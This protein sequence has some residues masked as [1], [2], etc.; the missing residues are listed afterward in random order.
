M[1]IGLAVVPGSPIEQAV[2]LLR[3]NGY[4]VIKL[5]TGSGRRSVSGCDAACT[6]SKHTA[7]CYA[8]RYRQLRKQTGGRRS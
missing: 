7:A 4:R 2:A 1:G 8:R 5:G 3:A 6:E